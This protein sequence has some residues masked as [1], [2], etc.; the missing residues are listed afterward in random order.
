MKKMGMAIVT[1]AVLLSAAACGQANSAN[2]TPET[3]AKVYFIREINAQSLVKI[4]A[5]CLQNLLKLYEALGREA[6]G[7]VAVKLST[8]EPGGNNF[9]QPAL[10]GDLVR[11]VDGTIVE[12]N[13]AYGGGRASTADHLK[14]AADHG[15]TAIAPVDIMDAEGETALPVRGG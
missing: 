14:A 1:S 7:N 6:K 11:K 9:L 10:I 2:R 5:A 15:F 12:C 13:T 4:Y 3:P 8:G